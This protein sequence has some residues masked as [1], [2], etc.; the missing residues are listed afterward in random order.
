MVVSKNL[1]TFAAIK[2][3]QAIMDTSKTYT[4]AAILFAVLQTEA[5]TLILR[6][7]DVEIEISRS[8]IRCTP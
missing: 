2:T 8:P 7:K 5:G 1:C 3:P 4:N 6:G